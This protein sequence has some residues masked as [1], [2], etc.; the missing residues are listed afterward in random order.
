MAGA[1]HW[2]TEEASGSSGVGPAPTATADAWKKTAQHLETIEE[3]LCQIFQV[4]LISTSLTV[5]CL[6]AGP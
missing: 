4:C 6:D 2:L 1:W 5:E 3:N